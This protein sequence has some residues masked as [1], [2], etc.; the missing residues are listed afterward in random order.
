MDNK[1]IPDIFVVVL[2]FALLY[3]LWDIVL[4]TAKTKLQPKDHNMAKFFLFLIS[5]PLVGVAFHYG[6][7]IVGQYFGNAGPF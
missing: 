6:S 4:D 3:F 7:D 2:C 5:L 1:L